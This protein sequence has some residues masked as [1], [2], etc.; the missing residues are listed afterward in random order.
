MKEATDTY[1]HGVYK[2]R[3]VGFGNDP[4]S[5]YIDIQ[6]PFIPSKDYLMDCSDQTGVNLE[7]FVTTALTTRLSATISNEGLSQED[8]HAKF[9]KAASYLAK[10][11]QL[12]DDGVDVVLGSQDWVTELYP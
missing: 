1:E 7:H 4:I 3:V 10:S 11:L 12:I 6:P 9:A 8:Q 5:A 2:A